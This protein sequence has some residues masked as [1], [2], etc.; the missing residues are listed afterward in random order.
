MNLVNGKPSSSIS[1]FDR[2]FLYG[3][4]VFET[5]LVLDKKPK[6]IDLHLKRLKLG[7]YKLKINNFDSKLL[8][9]HIKKALSDINNC[10][11]SINVT[12]GTAISRGYNINFAN[13]PNI[14]ITTSEIP[15]YPKEY[16]IKG[17]RTKFAKSNLVSNPN[18]SQIKHSN[19]IEQIL[20][21]KEINKDFPELILCDHKGY[22]IE[23][24]TSNIFFIKKKNFYTP[25]INESGVDGIMKSIIIKKLKQKKFKIFEKR[26]HKKDVNTYDAAF[27]CN[28]IR[29][30]WNIL[31]IDG[32][33]YKDN[34]WLSYIMNIINN[35]E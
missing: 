15:K 4:S 17:I 27:F 22:I 11:L 14:I 21:S 35:N 5:I 32:Y 16:S 28:S 23:G 6:N 8:S 10:V 34:E 24:I 18:L 9:K 29:L 2:G 12:R 20:A 31:S 19:R 30:V 33:K 26:I 3:D 7:C 1:I 13:N 25:I